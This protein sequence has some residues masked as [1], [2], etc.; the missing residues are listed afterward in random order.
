VEGTTT[1]T[2]GAGMTLRGGY[3]TIGTHLSVPGTDTIINEGTIQADASGR[4][5][6]I[7]ADQFSNNGT[8]A[9]LASGTLL[10]N[11]PSWSSSGTI[12]SSGAGSQVFLGGTWTGVGSTLRAE[13]SGTM[14]LGGSFSTAGMTLQLATSGQMRL[15]GTMTN[16][17]QTTIVDTTN[18]SF[19]IAGG[20]IVGGTIR[21][22]APNLRHF[23][24]KPAGDTPRPMTLSTASL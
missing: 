14:S 1:L 24:T 12:R 18:G 19:L 21:A 16:T 13:S 7:V 22:N 15:T 17:G 23:R 11:S 4:Y 10:V 3:G 9:G 8:L 20:Q 2:I 5:L 6:N